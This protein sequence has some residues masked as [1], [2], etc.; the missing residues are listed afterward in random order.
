MEPEELRALIDSNVAT[1]CELR[2]TADAIGALAA[3]QA[4]TNVAERPRMRFGPTC[5][6]AALVIS[7]ASLWTSNRALETVILAEKGEKAGVKALGRIQDQ[8]EKRNT[9]QDA[10]NDGVIELFESISKEDF[11]RFKERLS[12][13]KKETK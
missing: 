7:F 12:L 5:G 10:F 2:R 13:L 8:T 9:D 11:K 6:L 1:S 4:S 3:Q